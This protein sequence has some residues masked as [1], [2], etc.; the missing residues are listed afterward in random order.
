MDVFH[1]LLDSE[2]N[3]IES[4]IAALGKRFKP[5]DIEEL[6]GLQFHHLVQGDESFEQF[7]QASAFNNSAGKCFLTSLGRTLTDC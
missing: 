6:R 4:V 2:L 5:S 7:E 1:T 3:D